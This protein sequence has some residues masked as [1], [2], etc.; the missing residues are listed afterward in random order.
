[1]VVP[2]DE[3][4]K[5]LLQAFF[6]EFMALFFPELH[7]MIDFSHTRFLMQE[8]LVDVVGG[9]KRTVDLLVEVRLRGRNV[10]ILI[11]LEPQSYAQ[12]DFGERMFLYFARLLERHRKNYKVILPVAVFTGSGGREE[13]DGYTMRFGEERIV[14]FRYRKLELARQDWRRFAKSDNPVAAAL[15]ARMGYNEKDRRELRMAYL[16]MLARLHPKLDDARLALVMSIADLYYR[17]EAEEDRSILR[18]LHARDP[19]EAERVMELMPAWKRW[20]YEEGLEEGKEK[21]REE[22]VRKL[23]AKGLSPAQIADLLDLQPDEVAK[24]RDA[25]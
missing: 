24:L 17:P 5:K 15:L 9:E 16:K 13:P 1:M 10:Y 11:H 21:G 4:F 22:S 20:G 3:V 2:H 19:K 18:E 23:L 7:R 14:E 25:H 12:A 6:A 8:L